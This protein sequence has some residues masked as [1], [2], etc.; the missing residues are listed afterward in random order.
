MNKTT[1]E[2]P[3]DAKLPMEEA[4]MSRS[5]ALATRLEAGASALAA[6]AKTLSEAEWQTRIP[7]DGRKIGVVVHH[8]ASVY[9]VEIHLASLLASGQPIAGVSWDAVHTMNSDHA[10]GNDGVTKSDALALGAKAICVGRPYL[11]IGDFS[12]DESIDPTSDLAAT[13]DGAIAVT[14]LHLDLTHEATLRSLTK[15]FP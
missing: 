11:W 9:P 7:K 1:Y 15:L 10:K 8:V 3:M 2:Q 13:R 5:D 12:S 4:K 6:F 14:P